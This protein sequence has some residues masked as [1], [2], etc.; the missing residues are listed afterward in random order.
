M[1]TQ[2]RRMRDQPGEFSYRLAFWMICFMH[3]NPLLPFIRN[4]YKLLTTAGLKPGMHVLE[5]GC[6][7]GF[8]TLPAAKMVGDQGLV[9]AVDVNPFAIKRILKKMKRTGTKNIVPVCTNASKTDLPAQ[10]IDLAFLFGLPRIAGGMENLILEL[11]RVLKPEGR[12][13]FEKI[14]GSESKL[15]QAFKGKGFV[16]SGRQGPVVFLTKKQGAP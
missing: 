14:R 3:D 8:F 15:G 5:V 6:G 2:R 10:S 11:H 7:P 1:G 12:V 13:A 16:H 4:P 9:Y